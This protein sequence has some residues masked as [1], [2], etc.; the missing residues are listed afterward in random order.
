MAPRPR[1]L[2]QPG[3]D[4]VDGEVVRHERATLHVAG[5]LASQPGLVADG[6][7]EEVAGGDMRKAGPAREDGCLG[8]LA[9]SRRADHDVETHQRVTG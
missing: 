3:E 1:R 2:S 4:E 6:C 5:H 8:A 7:A 9:S